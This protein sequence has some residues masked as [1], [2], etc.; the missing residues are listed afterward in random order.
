MNSGEEHPFETMNTNR[1]V[2]MK[3]K[4]YCATLM[5]LLAMSA[6][7]QQVK[8]IQ[9]ITES[10]VPAAVRRAFLENY[11]NVS[12]GTWTVAFHVLNDGG[13][14]VAQPLSYTFKKGSGHN[15]IEVRLSP[16]GHVETA[17]GIEKV[18]PTT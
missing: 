8:K 15:K 16:D 4:M 13:K 17:K 9:T 7:A 1:N 10:E 12:E 14:S 6:T 5:L 18:P 11:G 3:L 2:T